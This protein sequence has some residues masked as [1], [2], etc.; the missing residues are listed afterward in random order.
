MAVTYTT[1]LG[2]AKP[3]YGT[4]PWASYVN[5]NWDKLDLAFANARF[6][7]TIADLPTTDTGRAYPTIALGYAAKNDGGGGLFVYN[8]AL[9]ATNN[10]GTIINGWV[11]QLYGKLPTVWMFGALPA[12]G[13]ANVTTNVAA[14]VAYCKLSGEFLYWPVGTYL[15][16]ASILDFHSVKHVG[17]GIVKRG[18]GLFYVQPSGS[19]SNTIY[20][21]TT[22]SSSNDGLSSS[23]PLATFQQAFDALKLYGP[24]LGGFWNIVAA[25]GTYTINAGQQTHSTPSLNRVTIRGPAAGHPNVPTCIVDGTGGAAYAHGLSMSGLGVRVTVRDI[26]FQNFTNTN[27]RIGLVGENESD[28]YTDNVHANSCDWCGIYAFNTV[29]ARISGGILNACRSGFV[30]NCTEATI[31]YGASSTSDGTVI[32][33]CTESGV[34]WSRGAQGHTDYCKFEDNAIG[35]L[36]AENSR[37]DTVGNNFKRNT[38]A[39]RA[40][41]GGVF[42]EGGAPNEFNNGTADANTTNIEY[43]AFAG[44]TGELV[45]AESWVRV[46]YDRVTRSASGTTPTTLTTPYTIKAYRLKGVGKQCRVFVAGIWTT[47][48]GG[49]T[50]TINFGGMAFTLTVP[51]LASNAAFELDATLYEVGG[52][53]RAIGVLR[54]GLSQQRFGSATA[55]FS[56]TTDQA[57][58]VA[59]TMADV[60]DAMNVYRTDVYLMG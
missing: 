60:G 24:M 15:T 54:Q 16:T 42:G 2:L 17:P 9:L 3:D 8:A 58:S 13:A 47:V 52:G 20:V 37:C 12:D 48:S 36:V 55:G 56:S 29:R 31:G 10:G 32:S 35:F 33:N 38:V 30:A 46:A 1:N 57:I 11:R 18:S 28:L 34:Y 4:D 21:A 6:V 39:V 40:R 50:I 53:Y 26:K 51:G 59:V 25:A 45:T 22:G 5:A 14:A 44:D 23:Q 41:T 7:N 49:S 19:Q 27:T 43:K